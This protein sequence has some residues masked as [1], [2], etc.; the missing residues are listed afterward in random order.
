MEYGDGI[1]GQIYFRFRSKSPPITASDGSNRSSTR[2]HWPG[3]APTAARDVARRTPNKA[4]TRGGGASAP[5][6]PM[7]A[8][9][10]CALATGQRLSARRANSLRWGP[11]QA[12]RATVPGAVPGL[13]SEQSRAAQRP[14]RPTIPARAARLRAVSRRGAMFWPVDQ[15]RL[16]LGAST[17]VSGD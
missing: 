14:R 5:V 2:V 11:P 12:R 4:A 17:T 13:P 10:P 6:R 3:P 15:S 8:C 1:W 16:I 7:A 9:G